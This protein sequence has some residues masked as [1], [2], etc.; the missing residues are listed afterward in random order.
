MRTKKLGLV[1]AL[2]SKVLSVRVSWDEHILF[3]FFLMLVTHQLQLE[4][5]A[6]SPYHYSKS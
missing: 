1:T 5:R 3:L 4:K 6:G 2:E